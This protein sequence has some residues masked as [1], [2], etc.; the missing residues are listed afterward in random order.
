MKKTLL[1]LAALLTGM[2]GMAEQKTVD[3][4]TA[5]QLSSQISE[6]E[7]FTITDLTITG[8]VNGEDIAFIRDMAG[9]DAENES[10]PGQLQTLDLSGATLEA[11]GIY[12]T[13]MQS[14]TDY[15]AEANVVGDYMFRDLTLTSIA[16]PAGIT[17]IGY[18]AFYNDAALATISGIENVAELGN[19]AF[20]SCSA[21][22]GVKLNAA[23]TEIPEALFK[24]CESLDNIEI[25]A[26][27]TTINDEAFYGCKLTN[28]T[29]PEGLV[30]VGKEALAYLGTTALTLPSTVKVLGDYSIYSCDDLAEITL[31]AGLET[32][33]E[34]ALAYNRAIK[35]YN[36]PSSVTS[37]G[38]S[39]FGNCRKMEKI[40]LPE[41]IEEIPAY[42]FDRCQVLTTI[43][44]P[45]TIKTI[46]ERAFQMCYAVTPVELPEGLETIEDGAFA[47][48]SSLTEILLPSTLR[49]IGTEAF[50][51]T[52]LTEIVI[53]EGV[54]RLG[55]EGGMWMPG[56]SVFSW[57]SD[58]TKVE[59]PSTIEVLGAMTFDSCPLTDLTIHAV[60][61]PNIV[62]FLNNPFGFDDSIYENCTIHVPAE[63]LEAYQ[64][65]EGWSQF[66]NIVVD[67]TTGIRE[68]NNEAQAN[69][70]YM[71]NGQR[72]ASAVKGIYIIGG[73]KV[74]VK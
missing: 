74:L 67:T 15:T 6:S 26:G 70:I 63:A 16:L 34:G 66:T 45:S 42:C 40:V 27:V 20:E 52:G 21:L 50:S 47:D 43:N 48:C 4:T 46:G 41:G 37:I 11:G 54:T 9:K 12:Y 55:G 57:C 29:L 53:P 59:L 39:A 35:E 8:K 1:S 44:F 23:L 65:D 60:T 30:S 25:P 56:G 71:P 51:S 64:N 3:L 58:L 62:G 7:K 49:N 28:L 32:I 2:V 38:K 24:R 19:A 18:R 69:D 5:G 17:K 13:N 36:I 10:T 61:P 72:A 33:G 31:N 14:A 22:D 73:K 68:M